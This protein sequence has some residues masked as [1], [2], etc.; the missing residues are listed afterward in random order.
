M[1]VTPRTFNNFR[2]F[3]FLTNPHIQTIMG[4]FLRG[5]V[6]PF[7]VRVSTLPLDDG[8]RLV[9]YDSC[10]KRWRP[11]GVTA[12]MVHG[13]GGS[14]RSAYQERLATL[15]LP[16]G[17]RVVRMDMRGAGKGLPLA[18]RTYNGGC[19][20]DIRAVVA[21][22]RRWDPDARI[23]LIGF[24]LG[25]N[26]VLKLA[27]EA[28]TW[29]VPGLEA[30]AALNPPID[31]ERCSNLIRQ[32]RNRIYDRHFARIL[33]QQVKRQRHFFPDLPP[34]RLP[35]DPTLWE[36]DESFTAPRAGF[37][38]AL[39]Y[40]RRSSSGPLVPAITVPTLI[41]TSRDDPFVAVEPFE[42]LPSMPN[43]EV[44]IVDRGGHLG[45]IGPDG[46]GR[47]RW[48]EPRLAEWI[49]RKTMNAE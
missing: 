6:P 10:P 4:T 34:L 39:D 35:A 44:R 38:G 24:S 48:A 9:M 23:I 47:F 1:S 14:H 16:H 30:V 20:N 17:I 45:F 25:G 46:R 33:V 3:P 27:G 32:P 31:L 18:R 22:M 13:L 41:M 28:A 11:G 26:I 49:I 29:P 21:E 42:E 37:Q 19:S 12:L 15:L 2:P 7:P 36:F 5:S 8:D 40:Y 43:V